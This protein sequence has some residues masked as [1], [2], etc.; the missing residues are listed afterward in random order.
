MSTQKKKKLWTVQLTL[1]E[2]TVI[3]K[4]LQETGV[5]EATILRGLIRSALSRKID[6]LKLI[7]IGAY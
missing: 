2:E 5:S 4:L 7:K 3:R 6:P 1:T